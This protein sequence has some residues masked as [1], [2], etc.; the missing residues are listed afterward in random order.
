MSRAFAGFVLVGLTVLPLPSARAQQSASYTL[1][2]SVF[3]Q[4]GNPLSGA[5]PVSVSYRLTLDA[6]GESATGA[7]LTSVS[8]RMDG[9]FL[10]GYPPP[11]EV[12]GLRVLSDRETIVWNP[13]RS[14]GAYN[15]Y[16]DLLSRLSGLAYGSCARGDIVEETTRDVLRPPPADGY[17]YLATAEN[18]LREEGTKGRDSGGRERPNASP[19]P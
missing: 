7:A 2:E 12:G 3:N 16:R 18:R 17:F 9:G 1:T 8:F 6:V 11:G 14:V 13:E 10:A 4:G 15:L 19:C 5:V